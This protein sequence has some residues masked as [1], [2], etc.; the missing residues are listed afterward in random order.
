MENLKEWQKVVFTIKDKKY[1]YEVRSDFLNNLDKSFNDEIFSDLKLDK[2]NFANSAY[3]YDSLG[4][5]WPSSK[6][7]DYSALTR[8]VEALFP[9]CDE[10]TVND[11]IVYSLSKKSTFE[12]IP[13]SF[14]EI[15][16][17]SSKSKSSDIIDFESIVQTPKIKL[18]FI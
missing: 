4:G 8:I 1:K 3:G 18:T 5:D 11:K 9:Y 15:E 6:H 14:F 13:V 16:S 2:V 7:A 10:V 12:E 17:Y